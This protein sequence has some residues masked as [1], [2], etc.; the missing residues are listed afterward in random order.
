MKNAALRILLMEDDAGDAEVICEVFQDAAFDVA[1]DHVP[2]GEKGMRFL[3]REG[4]YVDVRR[5]DLILLDLNMPLMDGRE[6]LQALKSDKALRTI[7]V[8]ILSTSDAPCDIEASYDLGANCYLTKPFGLDDFEFMIK[9]VESFW[10]RLAKL[11]PRDAACG[12][13]S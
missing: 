1:I 6:V 4:A 11:P 5:P 7:P 3:R 9:S 13:C 10:L 8:L 2:D 12:V